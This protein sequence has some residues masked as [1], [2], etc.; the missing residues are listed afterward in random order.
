LRRLGYAP[1]EPLSR[2]FEVTTGQ[3]G[4]V[5]GLARAA[6]GEGAIAASRYA[7]SSDNLRRRVGLETPPKPAST[8]S[9][10]SHASRSCGYLVPALP[11]D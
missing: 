7:S 8:G 9:G 5:F 4:A 11:A 10:P 6:G 2:R 3:G 1:S